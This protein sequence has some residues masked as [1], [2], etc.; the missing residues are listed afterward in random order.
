MPPRRRDVALRRR[1]FRSGVLRAR[2][3]GAGALRRWSP[4][5]CR[6]VGRCAPI[7]CARCGPSSRRGAAGHRARPRPSRSINASPRALVQRRH[8]EWRSRPAAGLPPARPRARVRGHGG[9]DAGA[10]HRRHHDALQR[11]ERRAARPAA[12]PRL[13]PDRSRCGAAELPALTYG[14]ASYRALPRLAGE[15]SACSPRFGAWAPRGFTLAGTQGPE[16]IGGAIASASFFRVHRRAAGGRPLVHRRRGSA[17]AA[18]AW[19]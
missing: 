8:G 9:G 7:R 1:A 17:V 19:R 16:R 13:G 15:R 14:S 10:G 18:N 6:R 2:D 4:P 5:W 11:G 12:L 3:R